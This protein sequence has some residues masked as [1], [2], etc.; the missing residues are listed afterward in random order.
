MRAADR[1]GRG[2]GAEIEA[3]RLRAAMLDD[4]REGVVAGQQDG[5]RFV[6]PHQDAL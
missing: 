6:V 2:E 4:L 3:L 1:A 5:E